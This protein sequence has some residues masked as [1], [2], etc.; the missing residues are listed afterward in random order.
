MSMITEHLYIYDIEER[1]T[2]HLQI[3]LWGLDNESKAHCVRVEKFTPFCFIELP[4]SVGNRF[5]EWDETMAGY[6]FVLLRNLLKQDAPLRFLWKPSKDLYGYQ[7]DASCL[8]PF[9]MVMFRTSAAMKHCSALLRKPIKFFVN[10]CNFGEMQTI[11][12]EMDIS[13]TRKMITA[14]NAKF[15]GWMKIIGY[16]PPMPEDN[17]ATEDVYTTDARGNSVRIEGKQVCEFEH[18]SSEPYEREWIV[19]WEDLSAADPK[20][21]E[22]WSVHPNVI[23]FDD[24]AYSDN[25]RIFPD[26][27]NE[28]HVVF[29]RSCVFWVSGKPETMVRYGIVTGDVDEIPKERLENVVIIRVKH[30][31]EITEAFAQ[32]CRELE[33]HII[34]GFNI[35]DFDLPFTDAKHQ[36]NIQPWPHIGRIPSEPTELK[37]WD[38]ASDGYGFNTINML[39][40]PGVVV[41]D[42]FTYVKKLPVK[43]MRYNLDTVANHYLGRGKEDVGYVE[44]F[45]THERTQ[46]SEK[47]FHIAISECDISEEKMVEFG[48]EVHKRLRA[49]NAGV[50]R[51]IERMSKEGEFEKWKVEGNVV[52]DDVNTPRNSS[53]Y[54]RQG[55]INWCSDSLYMLLVE[56]GLTELVSFQKLS[57]VNSG[58]EAMTNEIMSAYQVGVYMLTRVLIYCLVDADVT[59]ALFDKLNM[60]TD[61]TMTGAVAG[62]TPTDVL[63]KGQQVRSLSLLYDYAAKR[64]IVLNKIPAPN[65]FFNGGFVFDIPHG[66]KCDAIIC[67]DFNSLYP[68]IMRAYNICYTTLVFPEHYHQFDDE[69]YAHMVHTIAVPRPDRK[70]EDGAKY[71]YDPDNALSKD[72][73]KAVAKAVS[74]MLVDA[75]HDDENYYFRWVKKEVFP[76]VIPEIVTELV[77]ERKRVRNEQKKHA[78]GTLEWVMLECLQLATKC[79]ANSIFGFMGAGKI[80]KRPLIQGAMSI[81]ACGRQ[82]IKHVN[83]YVE[84]K[85]GARVVYGDSVTANTPIICRVN[86]RVFLRAISDLPRN[87][88]W[89]NYRDGKKMYEPRDLEVWSDQGFTKVKKVIRHYTSKKIYQVITKCGSEVC[90]T[91]DHSLLRPSGEEIRAKDIVWNKTELMTHPL[92]VLSDAE[93]EMIKTDILM[94]K[95]ESQY[96]DLKRAYKFWVNDRGIEQVENAIV[97]EIK[98]WGTYRAHVY[99]LETEN[100]HFAAGVGRLVVHNTDSSMIDMHMRDPKKYMAIG[101]ALAKELSDLFPDELVLECEKVMKVIF[102]CAKRYVYY[103]YDDAGNIVMDDDG[104]PHLNTKGVMTAR[105]DYSPSAREAFEQTIR[106]TL[107]DVPFIETIEY[108][109][110]ELK[111][112]LKGQIEYH[113]LVI[114]KGMGANYAK[115]NASMKLFGDRLARIGKPA[116]SGERIG[117]LMM[118][119]RDDWERAYTG[120][121]M[122]L[123]TE[124]EEAK[125]TDNPLEIDYVYYAEKQYCKNIDML[126]KAAY[127]EELQKYKDIVVRRTRQC[128]HVPLDNP[129]FFMIQ[130]LLARKGDPDCLDMVLESIRAV[131]RG[132][133]PL[134]NKDFEA[135]TLSA[136][137]PPKTKTTRAPRK[138]KATQA[139]LASVPAPPM[140]I[141][142]LQILQDLKVLATFK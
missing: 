96:H 112:L 51:Q 133:K 27:W 14:V 87:A 110:N 59:A 11:V 37:G 18:M 43:L 107:G 35:G 15:A 123:P 61:L 6:F 70:A 109:I 140:Y 2:D 23:S 21:V 66:E 13:S 16:H 122:F 67:V 103:T 58:W 8:K 49:V 53:I 84:Q 77:N 54:T 127:R 102:I 62:I 105:R 131:D 42:V 47:A 83:S 100:H 95:G 81:T 115:P 46:E 121:R 69:K 32:L 31:L 71:D 63:V 119:P 136:V 73:R 30:Q 64:G 50:E 17:Y 25:H 89:E 24:E 106:K 29:M 4:A 99:D 5:F 134:L 137:V 28:L 74:S 76:G 142:G 40:S 72:E 129:I 57:V 3:R 139:R 34:T 90:V 45:I 113:D 82:L 22:G 79:M 26:M 52:V 108:L 92:P 48:T 111:K 44:M 39:I 41:W 128:K 86:G 36:L 101:V 65:I 93:M 117:Y 98:E 132:E 94:E 125:D 78:K 141:D 38:W 114:V 130:L 19:D 116:K 88:V 10:G 75:I 138:S 85:Y 118:K 91:E 97:Q 68:S 20:D 60:F 1:D 104:L 33:V 80:G 56:V 12:S 55:K 135:S 124:Y 120:N 126:L 9:I 7:G